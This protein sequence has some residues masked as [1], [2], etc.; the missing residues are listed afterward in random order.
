M[1]IKRSSS[2]VKICLI[3]FLLLLTFSAAASVRGAIFLISAGEGIGAK[4]SILMSSNE[5]P[6]CCFTSFNFGV[7]INNHIKKSAEAAQVSGFGHKKQLSLSDYKKA[8][9]GKLPRPPKSYLSS[10][11]KKPWNTGYCPRAALRRTEGFP[12]ERLNPAGAF[13]LGPGRRFLF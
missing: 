9:A 13:L 11:R 8:T 10:E 2:P 4:P 7:C 3:W 5:K 1:T 6:A 12:S